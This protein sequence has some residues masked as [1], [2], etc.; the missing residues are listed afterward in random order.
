VEASI[1][2]HCWI[3]ERTETLN[4]EEVILE[5]HIALGHDVYL[6]T[7]GHDISSPTMAYKNRPITIRVG[8]W[9][10]SRVFVNPGITINARS[11]DGRARWAVTG[12]PLVAQTR[13][14]RRSAL[15]RLSR[16]VHF[17]DGGP[18]SAVPLSSA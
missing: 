10:T 8:T 14:G 3:G 4:L 2:D 12:T 5:D 9:I 15:R 7:A 16:V 13:T 11:P 1:G 6:A 18:E 17:P